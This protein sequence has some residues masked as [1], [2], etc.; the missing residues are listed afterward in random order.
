MPPPITVRMVRSYLGR[1]Q[2]ACPRVPMR[3]ESRHIFHG[4]DPLEL[5]RAGVGGVEGRPPRPDVSPVT[6]SLDTGD[7]NSKKKV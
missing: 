1:V 2:S 6:V 4:P 5:Q 7:I 3:A